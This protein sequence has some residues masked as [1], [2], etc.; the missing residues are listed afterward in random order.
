MYQ[1][2][3]DKVIDRKNTDCLKFDFAVQRGR[4]ADVLPFW[5]AD[6]D[7][8]IAR[9]IQEALIKRCEHGIFGYTEATEPY[10]AALHGWYLKH[11][12]WDVQ[13]PWLIKTPGVVFALAMAVKAFTKPGEAV[14]IQQPV[15]YPFSEVILDNGRELVNS[16]LVLKHGHYDMDFADLEA[17]L[18]RPEVKLMLLCSPHNPV[19]RVWTREELQK[20]GDLCLRYGVIVVADEIH[21]DFVWEGHKHTNFATL[22]E[23]YAQNCLVCTAPSKTFNLAGLQ[24]SNI[25]I[26]NQRLRR[27]FRKQ[28]DAAGYSQLNTLGLTA[29]Q[30]AY[31]YGEEWLQQVKQ[32]IAANIALVDAYLKEKL[33]QIK[34]MP[35]EGTYLIWLDCSALGMS[36][37]AREQ[38]L[39]HT[40][41]LWLDGGGI[42]GPEGEAFERINV[43]CPRA[44][45]LQGLEQLKSAVDALPSQ[46]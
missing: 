40:A 29:C 46:A 24:V 43:A 17:K 15:Y 39:W 44:T 9:E 12:G 28:V 2:D 10:F 19:G 33:P 37:A 5:V 6:M 16:P 21:S 23:E 3:F 30:A 18:A 14:L 45:L 13:R 8:P 25:F 1:Y 36:S 32:Y 42:F 11:F 34:L 35:I 20:V 41:K 22:G 27:A 4:P 26:P 38:W 7:F 31:T